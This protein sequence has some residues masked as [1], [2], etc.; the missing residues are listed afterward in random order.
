M[1]STAYLIVMV[2]IIAV[3]AAVA[4]P[5]LILKRCARCGRFALV[6][7]PECRRCGQQF[8]PVSP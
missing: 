2:G 6:D 1:S 7:T 4:T 3:V 5:A 8:P